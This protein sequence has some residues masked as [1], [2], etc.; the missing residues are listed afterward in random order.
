[1][2][3]FTLFLI[4][5]TALAS[6]SINLTATQ[7]NVQREALSRFDSVPLGLSTKSMHNLQW[8]AEV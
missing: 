8:Y 5:S 3:N 6:Q 7:R 4:F 1:M 2:A